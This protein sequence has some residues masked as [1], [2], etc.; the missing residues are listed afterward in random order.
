MILVTNY[1]TG[2]RSEPINNVI[3]GKRIKFDEKSMELLINEN[4]SVGVFET[5]PHMR[6][7]N[8]NKIWFESNIYH[9]R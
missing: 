4:L 3:P 1:K 8:A 5:V 9:L 7:I 6:T 2:L